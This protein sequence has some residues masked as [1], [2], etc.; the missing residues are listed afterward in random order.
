MVTCP[1]I[2]IGS[3][4]N[5]AGGEDKWEPVFPSRREPQRTVGAEG[6]MLKSRRQ[7]AATELSMKMYP[8]VSSDFFIITTAG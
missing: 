5:L 6:A 1:G 7:I 2:D 8:F 4:G 3:Q